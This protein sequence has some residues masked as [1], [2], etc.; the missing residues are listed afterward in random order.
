MIS[1][2]VEEQASRS[3]GIEIRTV[4]QE[5]VSCALSILREASQW[6]ATRGLYAWS[7]QELQKTDLPSQSAAG[8]LIIGFTHGKP[9]ACMLLQRSDPLYWPR[10][11]RG[12]ALYLHKL[13]VSRAHAGLGWGPRMISW[14]K[15]ETHRRG[16]RRLRLDTWPDSRLAELYAT[17]GFRFVDRVPHC[18]NRGAV[19][20]MECLLQTRR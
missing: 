17:Q 8:C 18:E 7:E 2:A 13:A 15:K 11:A 16:I 19:C 9:A 3:A 4:G 6:L 14:A 10:A 20:R 5:H 12:S 1:E